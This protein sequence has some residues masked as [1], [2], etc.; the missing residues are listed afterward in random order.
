[1]IKL[2]I[3]FSFFFLNVS[4][5]DSLFLSSEKPPS[6]KQD[7]PVELGM[8]FRSS[9]D[10][11]AIFVKFYKTNSA[12]TSTYRL[13]I[14]DS[15]GQ[16]VVSTTYRAPGKA[17][18]QRVRLVNTMRIK[19]GMP[20]VVAVHTPKG[21]Y[22]GRSKFFTVP[23][24]RGTLTAPIGGNG[25]YIYTKTGAYPRLSYNSSNYY[26]DLVTYP[27]DR[28]ELF[29]DAGRDT[30][31]VTPLDGSLLPD[32]N[33]SGMVDG[34]GVT[35]KWTKISPTDL[36]DTMLNANSL[37]PTLR[38]LAALT[39]TYHL[40]ATDR[41]G[42]VRT[43]EVKVD[44]VIHPKRIVMVLRRNGQPYLE[45]YQDGT[46]RRLG[47]TGVTG[48]WYFEGMTNKGFESDVIIEDPPE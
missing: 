19:A 12:D 27:E 24:T 36:T 16:R 48:I 13:S 10:A 9:I 29:V 3:L 14:Y 5:Q 34:D 37:T 45:I 44:V 6:A 1:M 26:V 43:S 15:I 39:H 28:K 20:Y 11:E 42:E 7:S 33:L 47:I 25:R 21:Y 2:T 41:W 46:W 22:G 35:Y 31:L 40:T 18:W 17:G 38:D 23:R 30:T 4:S 32:Y 8:V